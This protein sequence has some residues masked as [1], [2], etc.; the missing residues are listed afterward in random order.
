MEVHKTLDILESIFFNSTNTQDK[1]LALQQKFIFVLYKKEY[2][3]YHIKY[4]LYLEA[5]LI[6]KEST[7][8]DI[9]KIVH[10]YILYFES[11]F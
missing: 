1:L 5:L 9:H 2:I 6:S 3:D 11:L 10:E 7:F 8:K 4:K